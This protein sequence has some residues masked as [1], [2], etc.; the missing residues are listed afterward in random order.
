ML[1]RLVACLFVE[2]DN[3]LE[4]TEVNHINGIRTDN[5]A[6]NLEWVSHADNIRHSV[7]VLG[8]KWGKGAEK[9]KIKVK[10]KTTGEI[11]NSYT[12]AAQILNVR[13]STISNAIKR[14]CKVRGNILISLKDK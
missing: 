6:E 3:P 2:N 14:N 10:N 5:R 13:H 1:H 11:Y 12:E 8:T 7:C 9:R 4:K